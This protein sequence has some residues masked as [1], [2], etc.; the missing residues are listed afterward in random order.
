MSQP[1]KQHIISA[2]QFELS[3]VEIKVIRQRMLAH[4]AHISDVLANQVAFAVGE[5]VPANGKMSELFTNLP[6][7]AIAGFSDSDGKINP[8]PTASGGLQRTS[9]L[10]MEESPKDSIKTRKVAIMVADGVDAHQVSTVKAALKAAGALGVVVGPH[11]GT[12]ASSNGQE[13]AVDKTFATTPSVA[14]DAIFV[15]GGAKSVAALSAQDEILHFVNETHK[16]AKAIAAVA[17]G[18]DLLVI[19]NVKE[20]VKARTANL[21]VLTD[22][23]GVVFA[24]DAAHTQAVVEQ[25]INAMKQHRAW[26]RAVREEVPA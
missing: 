21:P 8:V 25:F 9:G 12:V 11:L 10:S 16:H 23:N 13:V 5:K 7:T 15:P 6:A 14:F 20:A 1:E 18:V 26:S 2:L 17:E 24:S 19:A 3:K 22:K 4:L